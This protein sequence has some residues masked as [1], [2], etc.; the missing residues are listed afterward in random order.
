M[1]AF[2]KCISKSYF[3]LLMYR[4]K[5]SPVST[6]SCICVLCNHR[7]DELIIIITQSVKTLE[8][9]LIGG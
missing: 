5:Q 8:Q 3:V 6:L 1:E 9:Q 4:L 2:V 7:A